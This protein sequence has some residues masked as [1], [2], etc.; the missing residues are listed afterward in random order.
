MKNSGST[1][2]KYLV[3]HINYYEYV[4]WDPTLEP[5][6]QADMSQGLT[7]AAAIS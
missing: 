6:A 1:K 5:S 7:T 3:L 2:F 4:F